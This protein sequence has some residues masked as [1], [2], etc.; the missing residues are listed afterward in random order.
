MTQ[1]IDGP[2]RYV[3]VSSS[4]GM[5]TEACTKEQMA[6]QLTDSGYLPIE[7]LSFTRSDK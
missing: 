5:V 7:L 6:H 2:A 3:S 1:H 4:D